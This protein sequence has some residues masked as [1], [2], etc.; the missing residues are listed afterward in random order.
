MTTEHDQQEQEFALRRFRAAMN[1]MPYGAS[2]AL[3]A[4]KNVEN[5]SD[6]ADYLE[7]LVTVLKD[8]ATRDDAMTAELHSLRS[9]IAAVRR[10]FGTD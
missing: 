8:V 10:L 1:A 9:D 3:T 6:A 7:S 2:R 4:Y 5:I